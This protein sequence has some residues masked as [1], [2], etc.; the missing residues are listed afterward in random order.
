[1]LIG[2]KWNNPSEKYLKLPNL[3]GKLNENKQKKIK[4]IKKNLMK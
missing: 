2:F 4:T 1:M 3:I